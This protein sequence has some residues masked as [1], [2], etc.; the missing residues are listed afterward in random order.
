MHY[1]SPESTF[2]ATRKLEVALR[3]IEVVERELAEVKGRVGAP[4]A[5]GVEEAY[6][7]LSGELGKAVRKGRRKME[8]TKSA[9][10]KRLAA[11]ERN[12]AFLLEERLHAHSK[13]AEHASGPGLVSAL[14]R[15]PAR[16]MGAR[17]TVPRRAVDA[18][19]RLIRESAGQ[20]QARNHPEEPTD[21]A[22]PD[23][24]P[25][26]SK[27]PPVRFSVTPA[28]T[29]FGLALAV[30]SWPFGVLIAVCRS[31]QRTFFPARHRRYRH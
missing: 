20:A 26:S 5:V 17:K 28:P 9:Q 23:E 13:K 27:R 4:P 21:L 31:F 7:D 29:S 3:R 14:L 6:D 15:L 8:A 22:S 24:R 16:P 10:N 2:S 12:I 30:L 18:C 11:L 19:T 25:S 1:P